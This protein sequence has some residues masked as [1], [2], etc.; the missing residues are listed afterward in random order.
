M[1]NTKKI[2]LELDENTFAWLEVLVV[3]L[4][5]E[6]FPESN[7]A[8]YQKRISEIT[9]KDK[10]D[11]GKGITELLTDVTNSLADGTRRSGSWERGC[12]QSLTGYDGTYVPAMFDDCIKEQAKLYGFKQDEN[13]LQQR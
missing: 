8:E 6:Q 11:F 3:G 9:R 5:R 4:A 12:L 13:I 7:Q 2:T 10:D 1:A